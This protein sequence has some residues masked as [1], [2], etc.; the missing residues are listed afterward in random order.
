MDECLQVE[1]SDLEASL[2]EN[3][4]I[5]RELADKI[6]PDARK[7]LETAS[8][9]RWG[10][11]Y[12]MLS[13]ESIDPSLVPEFEELKVLE[14]KVRRHFDQVLTAGDDARFSFLAYSDYMILVERP[15][16]SQAERDRWRATSGG[17]M[18]PRRRFSDLILGDQVAKNTCHFEELD[19]GYMLG[20]P[21][22]DGDFFAGAVYIVFD[23]N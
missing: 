15:W 9:S 18:F 17:D 5:L 19:G 13:Q 1:R 10:I 16:Q 14:L 8:L 6:A 21:A 11:G 3:L 2:K 23:S 22:V 12:A 4:C 20:V 7:L